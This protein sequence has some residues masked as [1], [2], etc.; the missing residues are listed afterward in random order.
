MEFLMRDDVQPEQSSIGE[1]VMGDRQ[2]NWWELDE[3]KDRKLVAWQGC[4]DEDDVLR[5]IP[6]FADNE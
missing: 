6:I 1:V 3:Y 2:E 5:L 4:F